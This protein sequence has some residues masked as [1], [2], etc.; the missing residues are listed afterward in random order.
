MDRIGGLGAR[1][2]YSPIINFTLNLRRA[3]WGPS[4]RRTGPEMP[5]ILEKIEDGGPLNFQ[6]SSQGGG[7]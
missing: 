6:Q 3:W 5:Q 2:P 4:K 7:G 1:A